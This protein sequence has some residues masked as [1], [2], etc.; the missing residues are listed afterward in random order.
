MAQIEHIVI[1]DN[2]SIN[3]IDRFVFSIILHSNKT[4]AKCSGLNDKSGIASNC[5]VIEIMSD[6]VQPVN[7]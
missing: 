5:E 1:K 2:L 3:G 7:D 6:N 4:Y